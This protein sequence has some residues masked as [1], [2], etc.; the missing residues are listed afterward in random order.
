MRWLT[1][2][3]GPSDCRYCRLS[4]SYSTTSDRWHT[5]PLDSLAQQDQLALREAE[6]HGAVLSKNFSSSELGSK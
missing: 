5:N 1:T 6:V 3:C 2:S 4:K